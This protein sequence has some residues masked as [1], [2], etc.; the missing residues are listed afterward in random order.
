MG[1]STTGNQGA[2]KSR[3]RANE[4]QRGEKCK[5]KKLEIDW[6]LKRERRSLNNTGEDVRTER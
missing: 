3:R 1:L 5:K 6:L 4:F 2:G